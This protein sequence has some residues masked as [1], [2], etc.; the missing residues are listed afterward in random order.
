MKKERKKRERAHEALDEIGSR[1]TCIGGPLNDNNLNYT[2]EQLKPFRNI[3][4]I[5]S[6][7]LR[8]DRVKND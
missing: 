1:L 7:V 8:E 4:N 5:C 6:R 2:K 3:E